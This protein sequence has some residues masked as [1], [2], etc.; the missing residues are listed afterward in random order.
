MNRQ[1]H[2][3]KNTH[4]KI[5]TQQTPNIFNYQIINTNL[6]HKQQQNASKHTRTHNKL[7]RNVTDICL[8]I[9]L[10]IMKNLLILFS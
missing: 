8:F 6:K 10:F 4:T 3:K 7:N 5:T 2:E 1:R 9:Y